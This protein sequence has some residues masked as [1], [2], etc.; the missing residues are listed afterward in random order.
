MR[1]EKSVIS[2]KIYWV[3]IYVKSLVMFNFNVETKCLTVISS[4]CPRSPVFKAMF[5]AD[6]AE[7]KTKKVNVK[8]VRPDVLS[9]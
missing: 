3:H 9:E 2:I 8:D 7:K 5:L 4:C 6:M 1:K